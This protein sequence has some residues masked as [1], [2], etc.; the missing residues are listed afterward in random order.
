MENHRKSK[1]KRLRKSG[2]RARM[3]SRNGRK[4]LKRRR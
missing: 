1:I 2:F 3:K 4:I